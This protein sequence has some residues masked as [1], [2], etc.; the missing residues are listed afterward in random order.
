MLALEHLMS[1]AVASELTNL[2]LFDF[3]YT[4]ND[5]MKQCNGTS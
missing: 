4:T 2:L 5:Q 3:F 1:Y